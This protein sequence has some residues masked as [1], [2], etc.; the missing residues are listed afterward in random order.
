MACT[1]HTRIEDGLEDASQ[2]GSSAHGSHHVTTCHSK[3]LGSCASR[4][5]PRAMHTLKSCLLGADDRCSPYTPEQ[6][7]QARAPEPTFEASCPHPTRQGSTPAT[8]WP[9]PTQGQ[10]W[11][12]WKGQ[13]EEC[14]EG[15]AGSQW[16]KRSPFP[17]PRPCAAR[18]EA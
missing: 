15:P 18:S 4:P 12:L 10:T 2:S 8:V 1:R 11:C 7:L 5:E 14:W 13:T 6:S 16:H 3:S 17:K 9:P